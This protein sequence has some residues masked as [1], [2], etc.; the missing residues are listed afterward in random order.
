MTI[1]LCYFVRFLKHTSKPQEKSPVP[2]KPL[3]KEKSK[4]DEVLSEASE[5]T[6]K[7][8]GNTPIV[9]EDKLKTATPGESLG[10]WLKVLYRGNQG[11]IKCPI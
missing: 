3:N 5:T 7:P 11:P 2:V 6:P 1:M 4:P 8:T 10:K 9:S